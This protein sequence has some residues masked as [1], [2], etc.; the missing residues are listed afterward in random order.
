MLNWYLPFTVSN[1]YHVRSMEIKDIHTPIWK[2]KDVSRSKSGNNLE[3][4]LLYIYVGNYNTVPS[5]FHVSSAM[6]GVLRWEKFKWNMWLVINVEFF[7]FFGFSPQSSYD[8]LNMICFRG[9]IFYHMFAHIF[10]SSIVLSLSC[11]KYAPPPPPKKNTFTLI[12]CK[13]LEKQLN[14]LFSLA[15]EECIHLHFSLFPISIL[16]I[17]FGSLSA[18][19]LFLCFV[20]VFYLIFCYCL[21]IRALS[22]ARKTFISV[23]YIQLNG[24]FKC[25]RFFLFLI[26]L[27][28]SDH[29]QR[30]QGTAHQTNIHVCLAIAFLK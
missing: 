16:L 25:F 14:V 4:F 3:R 19:F 27:L 13:S 22:P 17:V 23:K 20:E 5:L 6:F 21:P 30:C 24:F 1:S 29:I 7:I 2:C 8:V 11:W 26:F 28:L 10:F 12:W 15:N 18:F 9:C